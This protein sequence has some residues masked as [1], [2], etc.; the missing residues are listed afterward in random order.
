MTN[1]DKQSTGGVDA[2][3]PNMGGAG[4]G[5]K[6]SAFPAQGMP[7]GGMRPQQAPTMM[8]MMKP[9][10]PEQVENLRVIQE[11]QR[12][13]KQLVE[14]RTTLTIN[15]NLEKSG[16]IR[17]KVVN[18]FRQSGWTL[19]QADPTDMNTFEFLSK[20]PEVPSEGEVETK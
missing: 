16:N 1:I 9:P 15:T 19:V 13:T 18:C 2:T 5:G 3:T 14:G 6:V 8:D 17:N 7:P 11:V 10:S 4:N 20:P 12:L